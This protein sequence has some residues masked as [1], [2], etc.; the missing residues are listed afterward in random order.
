MDAIYLNNVAR[1]HRYACAAI[2]VNP[3]PPQVGVPTNILLRLKNPSHKP[4]TISRIETMVAQFGMGVRWEQLP[5]VGPFQLPA[6]QPEEIT[7]QWTPLKGGHRCIRAAIHIETIP[8][9]LRVGRNLHVIESEAERTIWRVP[10]HLGN[11]EDRRMAI[12]LEV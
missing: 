10:F 4:I 6:D 2:L 1:P 11:P 12:V 9:P 3:D 8:E 7:I 5:A